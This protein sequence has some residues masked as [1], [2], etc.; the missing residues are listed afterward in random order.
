[1]NAW[2]FFYSS[3][4]LYCN[5]NNIMC[6]P[7]LVFEKKRI[8]LC[9]CVCVCFL[10]FIILLS[11]ILFEQ[12]CCDFKCVDFFLRERA[13]S[14]VFFVEKEIIS[15]N[16]TIIIIIVVYQVFMKKIFFLHSNKILETKIKQ[17]RWLVGWL[18]VSNF[19]IHKL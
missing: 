19:G 14:F 11:L 16:I 10:H 17:K 5:N 4:N 12:F 13:D 8:I 6:G 7:V 18:F 3:I 15:K 9:L 2:N 1:M